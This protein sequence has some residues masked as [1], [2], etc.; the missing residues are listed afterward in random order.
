MDIP[1]G[2][3]SSTLLNSKT[4]NQSLWLML[5]Y[6]FLGGLLLNVMPCVLPVISLKVLGFV[7]HGYESKVRVRML[8]VLYGIG[9]FVS[10]MILATIVIS[11]KSAGEM[12]SWGMQLSLIHI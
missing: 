5:L 1:I 9:V 4:N 12:A 2:I 11:V 3:K 7:N 10:F 6:A 8:G